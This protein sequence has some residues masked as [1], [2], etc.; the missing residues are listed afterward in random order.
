MSINPYIEQIRKQ[1]DIEVR[2]FLILKN[3]SIIYKISNIIE[4]IA[5]WDNRQNPTSL[6]YIL[7]AK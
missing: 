5:F 4:I 6:E 2:E 3:F 1:E 7:E